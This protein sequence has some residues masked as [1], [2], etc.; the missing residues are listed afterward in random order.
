MDGKRTCRPKSLIVRLLRYDRHDW[1]GQ[2]VDVASGAVYPFTSFLQLQRL[3]LALGD[4]GADEG[5]AVG[6][7]RPEHVHTI[8][9]AWGVMRG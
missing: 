5:S 3:M 6:E 2:L 4:E 8:S 7:E 1:Q 9:A